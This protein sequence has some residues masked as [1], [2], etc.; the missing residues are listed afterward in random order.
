MK[1][2]IGTKY[3]RL[4]IRSGEKH[5]RQVSLPNFRNSVLRGIPFSVIRFI[6]KDLLI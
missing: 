5:I 1:K 2:P 4:S 3:L 6:K